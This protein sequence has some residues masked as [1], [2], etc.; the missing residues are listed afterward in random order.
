MIY[1]ELVLTERTHSR[2]ISNS[3]SIYFTVKLFQIAIFW[4]VET[5]RPLKFFYDNY[6]MFTLHENGAFTRN[7]INGF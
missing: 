7:G 3:N 6:G 2:I 1:K 4:N 5:Y